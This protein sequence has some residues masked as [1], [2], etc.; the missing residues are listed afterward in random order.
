MTSPTAQPTRPTLAKSY[1]ISSRTEGLLS[2][3]WVEEQMTRANNYWVTT[4]R[5]DGKPHSV[6]VLAIWLEGRLYFG[7]DRKARR[8]R[9]LEVNPHASVHLESADDVVI[10]EGIIEDVTD[11]AELNKVAHALGAKFKSEEMIELC[12]NP[13]NV[14]HRLTP[15]VVFAWIEKDYSNTATRWMLEK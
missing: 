15:Q 13:I 3:D 7:A 2:W 10:L 4:V 11:Q 14:I 9:N 8:S 5:P 6:P 1:G 12:L